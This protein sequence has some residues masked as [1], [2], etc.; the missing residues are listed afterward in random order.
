MCSVLVACVCDCLR[1]GVGGYGGCGIFVRYCVVLYCAV[2][3]Y[4]GVV[5]FVCCVL[6][7]WYV[8]VVVIMFEFVVCGCPHG[9]A[10]VRSLMFV[11][12]VC[13]LCF[14]VGVLLGGWLLFCYVTC[15][16]WL[17]LFRVLRCFV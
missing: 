15:C 7:V 12:V 17:C 1:S 2:C 8:D 3:L 9:C 6:R 16:V 11:V 14:S 13:L 4:C 5:C 10:V